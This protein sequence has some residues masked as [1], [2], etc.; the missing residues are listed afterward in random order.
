LG[1]GACGSDQFCDIQPTAKDPGELVP[2]CVPIRPCGLLNLWS[3]AGACPSAQT[4]AVARLDTGLTSCVA[5]GA[6]GEGDSCDTDHCASGLLCLG[7]TK[8]VPGHS[9]FRL[10]HTQGATECAAN[11]ICHTGRPTFL[12][13]LVGVCEDAAD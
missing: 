3:D 2:V 1:D 7:P 8:T 9:C 13:P 5:I 12:N 6:A 4:C 10:C 11:Q